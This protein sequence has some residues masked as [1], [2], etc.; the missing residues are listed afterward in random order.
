MK[1]VNCILLLTLL[2]ACLSGCSGSGQK[3][4]L[5]D[6]GRELQLDV[7]SG[8]VMSENNSHGGFHGDGTSYTVIQFEDDSLETAISSAEGWTALPLDETAQI[9]VYGREVGNVKNG[10]Y[11]TGEDGTSLI[12]EIENGCY[13]LKDRQA[14]EAGKEDER[15]MLSR[16]S[17]NFT[18]AIYDSDC[19]T[20][21]YCEMDT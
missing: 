15:D 16:P 6:I 13:W 17:L 5:R 7:S 4:V 3:D 10:P 14:D 21:H 8:T 20:L 9:L 18:I 1:K 12:P 19:K 11:L 2:T